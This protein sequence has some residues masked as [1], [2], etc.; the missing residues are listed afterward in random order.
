MVLVTGSTGLLGS[1]LLLDL[2]RHGKKVRALVRNREKSKN[3]EL[4]FHYYVPDSATEFLSTIEW[5]D[6][7]V[8]DIF[9]LDDE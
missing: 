2:V 7:D 5:F 9:S 3:V 4:L 1:H 8:C 6:G